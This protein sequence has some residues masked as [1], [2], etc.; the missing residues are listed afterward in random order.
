MGCRSCHKM[1]LDQ[2]HQVACTSC[3]L[4]TDNLNSKESSHQGLVTQPA[5]PDNAVASCAGCHDQ[6]L[7][8]V[9][10]NSHYSLSG[11]INNIRRAFGA[12]EDLKLR[13]LPL[14]ASE[15]ESALQLVDDLLRRRCLRCHVYYQGD[16]F[17]LVRHATGCGSCHLE[18]N[19]GHLVSHEFQAQPSDSRCLSCHY[20]NH[21]G[22]DYFGRYEHDYNEEYR[23]P[24]TTTADYF[25]QFGV[26]YH[27]LEADL[28]QQAGMVCLDCHD[29]LQIMADQENGI[30][31]ASC[32]DSDLLQN[33]VPPGITEKDGSYTFTSPAT[34][35]VLSVP[36]M[37]HSAHD[38]YKAMAS[39]QA[40]HA[41]WG[42]N[43]SETH[44]IRIDHDDFDDFYK[45]SLDGSSEVNHILSS[46]IED[47]GDWL[48][49][50][51]SDKFTGKI[52][53][54]IWYKGFGERRWGQVLLT[55]N[56]NG[57]I[58]PAR[59]ILDLKLSWI[60]SDETVHFDNIR[61]VSTILRPYTP[62]T[63]G[64]AG[65]FYEERIRQ[66]LEQEKT[67][68]PVATEQTD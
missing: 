21:V 22:A 62:H 25:R 51:M 23:T 12:K 43:D 52:S 38:N 7:E 26:E 60:D 37:K 63:T 5:H 19:N 31:C 54:G 8:M 53:P 66:F 65:I 28:H 13:D 40:C 16:D 45:L 49:P 48:E 30:L 34:A 58:V 44:L 67:G 35:I 64:A 47:D 41:R 46:H 33:A 18:F 68:S 6:E 50:F 24:Y 20:G 11:H 14:T 4:G 36:V 55:R 57:I 32:H 39:C 42:F 1:E 10:N 9:K 61:P 15:P 17:P 2:N 56:E 27:Q 3:H 59:P 29:Q